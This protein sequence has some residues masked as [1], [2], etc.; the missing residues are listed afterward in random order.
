M[1]TASLV[2]HGDPDLLS[3]YLDGELAG[4][5]RRAVEDHLATCPGCRAELDGL[6]RV[7]GR[8]AS[9]ERAAP[10][11][12]LAGRVARRVAVAGRPAGLLERLEMLLLRL[13]VE[14]ATLLSFGVVV[15]LA[16]IAAVFVAS[17]DETD[18]AR[19]R[20]AEVVVAESEPGET[21]ETGL[22]VVTV[23]VNGRVLD[24]DGALWRERGLDQSAEDTGARERVITAGSP[25]GRALLEAEPRLRDLL[26]GSEG[27]VLIGKDGQPLRLVPAPAP[28][29]STE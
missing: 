10:P 24:R 11:P 9:L 6:R 29:S 21:T 15:A 7:V 25:E 2:I 26:T 12:V 18:R 23:H 8:L 27:I 28:P 14:P 4:A 19:R 17:V 3:S 20:S 13:P 16:A 5:E 1:S 22:R